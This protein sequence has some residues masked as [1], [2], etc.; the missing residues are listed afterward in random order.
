M[1]AGH[2][3]SF[4]RVDPPE[5]RLVSRAFSDFQERYSDPSAASTEA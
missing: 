1:G 5:H 3:P 2:D 4:S